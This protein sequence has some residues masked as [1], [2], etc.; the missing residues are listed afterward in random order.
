MVQR[1]CV[2]LGPPQ[3]LAAK[4]PMETCLWDT[5]REVAW[6]CFQMLNSTPK[7][8]SANSVRGELEVHAATRRKVDLDSPEAAATFAADV[9]AAAARATGAAGSS[10]S[11]VCYRERS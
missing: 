10:G 9:Q 1:P 3:P 4:M 2:E 6:N 11:R 8:S 7:I 5:A